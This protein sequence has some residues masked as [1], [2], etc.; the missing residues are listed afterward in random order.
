MYTGWAKTSALFY[1]MKFQNV[2][3]D[4]V[5]YAKS[6]GGGKSSISGYTA[7]NIFSKAYDNSNDAT[8]HSTTYNGFGE[9]TVTAI[10]AINIIIEENYVEKSK[11]IGENLEE[12]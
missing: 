2:C 8:L 7:R 6:F 11:F 3:P 1:F 4:I 5:T 9:E 10:E 12:S